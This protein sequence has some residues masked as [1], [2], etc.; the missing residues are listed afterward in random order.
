M[1]ATENL[2][3]VLPLYSNA[4]GFPIARTFIVLDPATPFLWGQQFDPSDNLFPPVIAVPHIPVMP[5]PVNGTGGSGGTVG[6][7]S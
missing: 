5:L 6:Y 1:N 3:P 4:A 2:S 7:A